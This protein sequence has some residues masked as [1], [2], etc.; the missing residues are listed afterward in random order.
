MMLAAVSGE[1][2]SQVPSQD[3]NST[4]FLR[5]KY[6]FC[7]EQD[8]WDRERGRDLEYQPNSSPVKTQS[9][10]SVSLNLKVCLSF[11][12]VLRLHLWQWNG[13]FPQLPER[14][15][16]LSCFLHIYVS[17]AVSPRMQKDASE[18]TMPKKA[19]PQQECQL[20]LYSIKS[21]L[22]QLIYLA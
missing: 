4:P 22:T 14:Q 13:F 7:Q 19:P 15:K 1:K 8:N 6:I 18:I 11:W 17:P 16:W 20:Q 12:T 5:E 2:H 3:I 9:L 10:H 21:G